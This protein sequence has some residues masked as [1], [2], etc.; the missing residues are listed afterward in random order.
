[1]IW[2]SEFSN[3]A[4]LHNRL[5]RRAKDWGGI[6]YVL[7][8]LLLNAYRRKTA[9]DI[10]RLFPT[11]SIE[12]S[13]RIPQL[14]VADINVDSVLA[15]LAEWRP[16]AVLVNG[17]NL[18]RRR[19][20]EQASGLPLGMINLHTGLSPY[21]RG[22]NC[23]LYALLENRPEHVGATVHY[24]DGGI[25]SGDIILS[26]RPVIE[27]RDNYELLDAKVFRLGFDLIKEAVRQISSG[28]GTRVKQWL[29]GRLY[30]QRTG[31]QYDIGQRVRANR[32][33]RRMAKEAVLS[34][35]IDKRN[36]EI[37]TVGC[38]NDSSSVPV[39]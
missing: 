23:N 1:V 19:L 22:G 3:S 32:I 15:A 5:L 39:Y 4:S 11:C 31:Y 18:I 10:S 13:G 27:A 8:R 29:E 28:E 24:I 30:L 38:L 20:R 6:K 14:R 25:D 26:A 35:H 7:N 12:L 37:R 16:D 17:T 34:H 9:A 2:R 33:V 36:A 21:T